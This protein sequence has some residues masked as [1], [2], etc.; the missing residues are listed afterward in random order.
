MTLSGGEPALFP[1][2]AGELA[3]RLT[4]RGIHVLAETSGDLDWDDFAAH[5]LPHL[6]AIYVDVKLADPEAHRAHTGRDGR[7]IRE[8]LTRL[9]ALATS[10][11][12]GRPE[13]L[14]RVPLIP[15]LTATETNLRGVAALLRHLGY[16][17]VALLPYNPLWLPKRRSLGLDPAYTHERWMTPEDIARCRRVV[18]AAGLAVVAR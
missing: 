6:A 18:E 1:A 8:T 5:L 12:A 16:E 3:R 13:V 7:R 17:R 2:F 10:A 14:P 15:D 9:A 11:T 4:E